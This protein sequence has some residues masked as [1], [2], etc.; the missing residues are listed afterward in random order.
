MRSESESFPDS[1]WCMSSAAIASL[2]TLKVSYTLSE[3]RAISSAVERFSCRSTC[4]RGNGF[5]S[6]R[7][8]G[9]KIGR[10]RCQFCHLNRNCEYPFGSKPFRLSAVQA[11]ESHW[12]FAEG[13]PYLSG[14]LPI[15]VNKA[16]NYNSP[17]Q[18]I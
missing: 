9:A 11:R 14:F 16:Q 1:T 15:V 18:G 13:D 17:V 12:L 5:E 7:V 6:V 2:I 3:S 8:H 10:R 4:R